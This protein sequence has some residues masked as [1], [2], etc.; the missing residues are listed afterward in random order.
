MTTYNIFKVVELLM[1]S[2]KFLQ[3]KLYLM[4]ANRFRNISFNG[5]Y[6][7][8]VIFEGLFCVTAGYWNLSKHWIIPSLRK[9][10]ILLIWVVKC[11]RK[12]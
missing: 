3:S 9:V 8:E 11:Y 2:F 7:V 4:K 10:F 1:V 12:M 5:I 6:P